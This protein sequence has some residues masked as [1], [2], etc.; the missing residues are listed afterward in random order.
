MTDNSVDVQSCKNLVEISKMI[1]AVAYD[2]QT[3]IAAL[4]ALAGA[5][6]TVK[7]IGDQIRQTEQLADSARS[8]Q[9]RATKAVLPL[10]LSEL[11]RYAQD[12]ILLVNRFI[13]EQRST[14]LL[15]TEAPRAPADV[16]RVLQDSVRYS[17]ADVAS[18][19][20]VLLGK[21]QVQQARLGNLCAHYRTEEITEHAGVDAI[22]DAA[23]VYART[24]ALF[25]YA[26]DIEGVRKRSSS[27]ELVSA[28]HNCSIWD[29]DHPAMRRIDEMRQQN[30]Q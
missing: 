5:W 30:A 13:T 7:K 25:D 28:L 11:S 23:D 3:L 20:A 24:G 19:I 18:Q 26:R 9:E 22:I 6:L 10:A 2:W 4:L 15:T 29:D 17:G 16:I 1:C 12:C 21:I 14:G 8:R 27:D